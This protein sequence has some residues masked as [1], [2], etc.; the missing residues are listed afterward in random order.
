MKTLLIATNNAHKLEEYREIL[1]DLP[2]FL[3]SLAEVGIDLDPEETGTTFTENAVL[4]AI[5]FAQSANLLTLADDS[6]LEVDALGGEPGVY[7]ARYGDTAKDDHL[8]RYRLVLDRLAGIPWEQRTGRFKCVVA[9]AT[10]AGLIGTVEGAVE[11][12]IALDP[13]GNGGFG[14]D[15]IFFYPPWGQT[16]AQ[17]SSAQKH[18]I[19]HRGQAA[20]AAIPLIQHFLNQPDK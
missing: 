2:I 11:G 8:G 6:G 20:R 13:A 1:A 15:P 4:K 18:S 19:S 10:S 7:S 3:V 16:L 14:Y 17:I 9:L 12:Y 5:A